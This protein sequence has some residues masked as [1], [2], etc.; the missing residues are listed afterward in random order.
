MTLRR[1][2]SFAL[3]ATTG[4][5]FNAQAVEKLDSVVAV[6]NDGIVLQSELDEATTD[7]QRQ[8]SG[9][10]ISPP[11]EEA[12]RTQV[13]DRL[14]LMRLQTQRAAQAGIRVDDRE[15]NEVVNNVAKQNGLTPD[16]FIQRIEAEGMSYTSVREQIRDEVIV[17]RLRQKEVDSRILVTD[18]DVDLFLAN[19]ADN[20]NQEYRASHILVAVPDGA[21]PEV[22]AEKKAKAED[23]LKRARAGEDFAQLAIANSDGR[24][25][26]QGGDLDWRQTGEIPAAFATALRKMAP[27]D[28]SDIVETSGGY[29]ILKLAEVRGGEE[30]RTVT[31]TLSKH[32]LIQP[33]ALRTEDQA[34]AEIRD[35][36][37]RLQKGEDFATL[38]KQYSD[39]PGSKNAGGELGWLA[40]GILVPEF[41]SQIDALKPGQVSEPFHSQFGWHIAAVVDRRTRDATVET[42][43]ARARQAIMQ[44]K[45]AEEYDAWLRR[46]RDEAYVDYRVPSSS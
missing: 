42:R 28:I 44:R 10:G 40:P 9:R 24:Q 41:Q 3:L 11:S 7:A 12:L 6:V 36:Y 27:G 1:L 5:V 38:A 13:L 20:T 34:R 8:L 2:L 19:Q 25:A 37:A 14:V 31:E 39:D 29:N 33:N 18:Q 16:Q 15:L 21:S 23:L 22:R 17:N 30:R 43:R 4:T 32:I 35:L 26:L 46:L 45:S